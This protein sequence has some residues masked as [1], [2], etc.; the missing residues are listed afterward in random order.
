M[1]HKKTVIAS[2]SLLVTVLFIGTAFNPA[3][4]VVQGETQQG[5]MNTEG[6]EPIGSEP[7]GGDGIPCD[8]LLDI[9]SSNLGT[10][11]SNAFNNF[12]SNLQDLTLSDWL[13]IGANIING[14]SNAIQ[15]LLDLAGIDLSEITLS[16][17]WQG[18]LTAAGIIGE[19]ADVIMSAVGELISDTV[20][21][22]NNIVLPIGTEIVEAFVSGIDFIVE[23]FY[24]GDYGAFAWD[25]IWVADFL[26]FTVAPIL[27]YY[28]LGAIGL[29]VDITIYLA[30]EYV[31]CPLLAWLL[32][33]DPCEGENIAIDQDG[34]MILLGGPDMT[35]SETA[36][37]VSST[38][39][40]SSC[41]ACAA[42]AAATTPDSSASST[43]RPA[44]R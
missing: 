1:K 12:V 13:A 25:C 14:G 30:F 3:T 15:F 38:T 28:V 42:V 40:S 31:I 5:N 44:P 17:I 32:G 20:W 34:E 10:G 29:A 35:G 6:S 37:P 23:T 41:A 19:A 39:S 26:L 8:V 16:D 43:I 9:A 36:E 21:V 18:A 27:L 11:I 2:I 22:I 7:A 24:D 4:A 33:E